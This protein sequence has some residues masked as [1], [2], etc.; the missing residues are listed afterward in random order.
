MDA[1][2]YHLVFAAVRVGRD[3]LGGSDG[4]PGEPGAILHH[5]LHLWCFLFATLRR[6]LRL[7][8]DL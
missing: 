1:V 6:A 3:V 8:E 2:L 4:V 7:L 5:L